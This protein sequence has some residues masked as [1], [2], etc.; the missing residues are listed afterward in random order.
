MQINSD[1]FSDHSTSSYAIL[2]IF[3]VAMWPYFR[4]IELSRMAQKH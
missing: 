4:L 1:E 2:P 3:I